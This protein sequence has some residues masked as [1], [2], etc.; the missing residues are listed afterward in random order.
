MDRRTCLDHLWRL[1]RPVLES[2][3]AGRLHAGLPLRCAPGTDAA[4]RAR[5]TH[6]EA[7]GRTLAGIAPWLEGTGGDA[8]EQELRRHAATTARQ[9]LAVACDLVHP[10][11]VNFAEGQQPI[12]D[13]AFLAHALVRAPG[14]LVAEC[15]AAV[16]ANLAAALARTRDRLAF[17][18]NWL[19]FAAMIEAGLHRLGA[20]WDPMRVDHALRSHQQWYVGDGAY[21][22]GPRFHHDYYNSFVIQPM[23]VDV[24]ATL[25][26]PAGA[27]GAWA[28]LRAASAARFTRAAAVQERLI[29]ADGSFPPLGRSLAYRCG[30]F[31]LLAQAALQHRLPADLAP[32]QVRG[33]LGA[34]IARTLGAPGTYDA[35]GWLMPGLAGHQPGLM[36]GYISTGSLY[37]AST[38]FL[39][40][41]LPPEDPF[42]STPAQPW[43]QVRLWRGEDLPAD[44]ALHDG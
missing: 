2:A 4:E 8:D 26:E 44:H 24:L 15:P 22:D 21:G 33:A 35:D 13:A 32:A 43:T 25:D 3:A 27:A 11:R 12:V 9:A 19:L 34:V 18:N 41:G 39:P 30:A 28:G 7:L 40:L 5:F 36:E 1:A 16:R 37:L 17:N 14:A 6:L 31:Q 23:L 42:W 10:D 38:A 20:P 29:A